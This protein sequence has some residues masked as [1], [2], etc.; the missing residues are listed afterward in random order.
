MDVISRRT[1]LVRA[2]VALVAASPLL[3][4]VGAAAAPDTHVYKLVPSRACKACTAC[5]KHGHNKLF[6]TAE[7][8]DQGR[9]HKGCR[10]RVRRTRSVG[11]ARRRALFSPAGKASRT[12]VDLR[13]KR[14][15]VA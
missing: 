3:R 15:T 12:V 10:C 13:W 4:A 5:K 11:V 1:M 9:A 8:A 6:A 14:R 7:A 2:G